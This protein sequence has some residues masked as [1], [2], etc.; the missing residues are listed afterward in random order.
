MDLGRQENLL[1]LAVFQRLANDLL[2]SPPSFLEVERFM[3]IHIGGIQKTDARIQRLVDA[4]LA[5]EFVSASSRMVVN[6]LETAIAMAEAGFGLAILPSVSYATCQRYRVR[7]DT[8]HP[9][10]ELSFDCITQ[11]GRGNMEML[12]QLSAVFADVAMSNA[13][14]TRAAKVPS[15]KKKPELPGA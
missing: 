9:V 3:P 7:F 6:H 2:A 8:I 15:R 1:A 10:I 12:Q 5:A 4:Q 13:T 11:S 14:K